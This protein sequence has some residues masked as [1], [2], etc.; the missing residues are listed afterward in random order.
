MQSGVTTSSNSQNIRNPVF[1]Y[2]TSAVSSSGQFTY[3]TSSAPAIT[4]A[5]N[6]TFREGQAGTFT[7]T[8]T[9]AP[10]RA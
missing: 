8:T 6:T 9:G 2:G 1:G 4:S 10:V 5:D 3:G 7:V